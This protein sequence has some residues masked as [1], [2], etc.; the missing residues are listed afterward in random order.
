[1]SAYTDSDILSMDKVTPTIAASYLKMDVRTLRD[2]LAAGAFPFGV[3]FLTPG[4]KRLCFDIRGDAL[5]RYNRQGCGDTN[6]NLLLATILERLDTMDNQ[7]IG[8]SRQ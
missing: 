3:A 7:K 4:S 8:G 1:M 6:T 2:G 5:V